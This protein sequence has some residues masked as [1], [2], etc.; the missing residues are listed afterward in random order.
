MHFSRH[1]NRKLVL[2]YFVCYSDTEHNIET[3]SLIRSLL[4]SSR[5]IRLQIFCMLEIT[6]KYITRDL[7]W[8]L[9]DLIKIIWKIK[10]IV[11]N[12]KERAGKN[13]PGGN[14]QDFLKLGRG[15]G[16]GALQLV[17]TFWQVET[18]VSECLN[19]N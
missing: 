7:I 17:E 6:L 13:A 9:W 19:F 4:Y 15:R 18:F 10:Y 5:T 2:V 3:E 1:R 8:K 16:G 11:S 14:Y 12:R